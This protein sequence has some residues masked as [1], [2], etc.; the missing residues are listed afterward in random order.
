MCV[1]KWS[2]GGSGTIVVSA[3]GRCT[4]DAKLKVSF[5]GAADE[6]FPDMVIWLQHFDGG[7]LVVI[8]DAEDAEPQ[9]SLKNAELRRN[10]GFK[11]CPTVLKWHCWSDDNETKEQWK[12]TRL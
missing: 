11:E 1:G 12:W 7:S 3:T 9:R 6:V 2:D 10:N 8:S 4:V 5:H